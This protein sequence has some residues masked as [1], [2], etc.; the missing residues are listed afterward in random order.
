[1]LKDGRRSVC[2]PYFVQTFLNG[3]VFESGI[4]YFLILAMGLNGKFLNTVGLFM[5][6][7]NQGLPS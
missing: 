3:K 4:P 1:M 6:F 2:R 5:G 7:K